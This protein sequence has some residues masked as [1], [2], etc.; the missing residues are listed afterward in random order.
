MEKESAMKKQ[1]PIEKLAETAEI[2]KQVPAKELRTV[3]TEQA[4]KKLKTQIR[5]LHFRKNYDLKEIVFLLKE[6]GIKATLASVKK[7]LSDKEK[8]ALE[9]E[10]P[11][12]QEKAQ[13]NATYQRK[14]TS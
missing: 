11:K 4:L 8:Q 7:L 2:L 5:N 1:I 14:K 10:T 6:N 9:S 12:P 13:K 3:T